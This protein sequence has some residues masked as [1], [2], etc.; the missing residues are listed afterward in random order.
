M[1]RPFPNK[2]WREFQIFYIRPISAVDS[3]HWDLGIT[4]GKPVLSSILG[5]GNQTLDL[6]TLPQTVG[7][8]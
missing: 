7:S 4:G 2:N 6:S 3:A 5:A 8:L 1:I